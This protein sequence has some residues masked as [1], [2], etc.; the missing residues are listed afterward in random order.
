MPASPAV[1]FERRELDHRFMAIEAWPLFERHY[2]E[3]SANQDIPLEPDIQKYVMLEKSGMLRV[4]TVRM[5]NSDGQLMLVGYQFLFVNNNLHYSNSKQATQ[6]ILFLEKHLRGT[7]IGR[8]FIEWCDAQL[9][10]E[11]VQVV[12]QHVK[13]YLNFGPLLEKLGYKHVENI[14]SRRLDRT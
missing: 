13:T 14:Y 3:V 10:K 4:Y 9:R 5:E 1:V 11:G 7:G 6:D 2:K 8:A 12:Y